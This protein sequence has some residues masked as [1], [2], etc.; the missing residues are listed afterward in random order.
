MLLFGFI[1]KLLLYDCFRISG[2][3]QIQMVINTTKARQS[4][5][6]TNILYLPDLN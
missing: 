2:K 6:E 5:E 1:K 3:K 4:E